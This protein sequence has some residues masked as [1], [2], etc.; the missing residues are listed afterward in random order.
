MTVIPTAT[1]S[2]MRS[3]LFRSIIRISQPPPP[4]AVISSRVFSSLKRAERFLEKVQ[5]KSIDAGIVRQKA[6]DVLLDLIEG[7]PLEAGPLVNQLM[8]EIRE[9]EQYA[10]AKVYALV[11]QCV[12][13]CIR[14]GFQVFSFT[15]VCDFLLD[16][17]LVPSINKLCRLLKLGCDHRKK[18]Q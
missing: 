2:L 15:V 8:E 17:T 6:P 3:P 18:I 1:S 12:A 5:A 14:D 11:S 4:R 10:S 16:L 9:E 7:S 13:Y